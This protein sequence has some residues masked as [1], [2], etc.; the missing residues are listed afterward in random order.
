MSARDHR[1]MPRSLTSD[2]HG[3]RE[4]VRES[5]TG[6]PEWFGGI[7]VGSQAALLSLLMVIAPALTIAASAPTVD[8]SST[9]DW[10]GATSLAT[11]VWL[12][13]HG[14][15]LQTPQATFSIAPLGLTLISMAMLVGIARRFATRTWGSWAIAVAAYAGTVAIVAAVMYAESADAV[16]A[17]VTATGVAVVMAAPSVAWGIWRAHGAEFGWLLRVPERLRTGIRLAVGTLTL[18]LAAAAATGAVCAYAG[19]GAIAQSA[20]VLGLDVVGGTLLAVTE[21][22]YVPVLVIWMLAWLTGQGFAVGADSLY[23]PH[24]IQVGVLPDVPL[25]GAL[26][27]A[28]GGLVV[29]VPLVLVATAVIARLAMRRRLNLHWADL[30]SSAIAVG[31]VG[32]VVAGLSAL[33]TG[34]LGPGRMSEV[35][36]ASLPVALVAMGFT[37]SGY[38]LVGGVELLIVRV[39]KPRLTKPPGEVALE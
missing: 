38:V 15:P 29:W 11:H 31:T 22:L 30:A 17:V 10:A 19:R 35:G 7:L 24:A 34:S 39:L 5:L 20:S 8:R 3:A 37:A 36:V 27:S 12:L 2:L 16:P 33:A 26:P 14:V 4:R 1:P 32:A 9:V 23:A 6:I 21:T 28:S 25:L 13:A 18:M